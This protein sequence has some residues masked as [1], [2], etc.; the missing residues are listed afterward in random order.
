MGCNG[1]TSRCTEDSDS[2]GELNCRSLAQDV[3]G[4]NNFNM[5]PRDYTCDILVKNVSAF[6]HCLKSL[7][8]DKVKRFR[9]TAL[10]KEISK[11]PRIDSVL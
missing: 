4:E 3:S 11:Y 10:T 8:E 1:Y 9:L 2:V 7:S 6:C 5:C